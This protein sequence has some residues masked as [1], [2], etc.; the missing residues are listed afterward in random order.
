MLPLAPVTP[1]PAFAV[2]PAAVKPVMPGAET[3]AAPAPMM[4]VQAVGQIQSTKQAQPRDEDA[5]RRQPQ[6]EIPPDPPPLKGLGVPALHTARV[7]DF[8]RPDDLPPPPRPAA[9]GRGG[10]LDAALESLHRPAVP[11]IDLRR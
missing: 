7:G 6:A 5:R 8:D 2:S 9:T 1:A 11:L 3:S 10:S 4:G